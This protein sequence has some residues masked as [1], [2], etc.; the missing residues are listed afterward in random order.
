MDYQIC[1]LLIGLFYK[2]PIPLSMINRIRHRIAPN[3]QTLLL[4]LANKTTELLTR[5][6]GL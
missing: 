6:E 4:A 3:Q 5:T 1:S 2:R